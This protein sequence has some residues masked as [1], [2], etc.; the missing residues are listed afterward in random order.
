[1]AI[2][3]EL[4]QTL[5]E[6]ATTGH[7]PLR[8]IAHIIELVQAICAVQSLLGHT[9]VVS[10][11]AGRACIPPQASTSSDL[12]RLSLPP[13]RPF[14]HRTFSVTHDSTVEQQQRPPDRPQSRC[15]ARTTRHTTSKR[16][17]ITTTAATSDHNDENEN[18]FVTRRQHDDRCNGEHEIAVPVDVTEDVPVKRSRRSTRG[19]PAKPVAAARKISSVFKSA[20]SVIDVYQDEKDKVQE[21]PVPATPRHRDAASKKVPI[22]PRHRVLLAGSPFTPRTPRTPSTPTAA[23]TSVYHHARRLFSRCSDPGRLVGRDAERGDITGFLQTCL[24]ST[25]G[26]CLYV[27]GP[28]GTGKSALIGEASEQLARK[29]N[30]RMTTVNCMSVRNTKDLSGKLAEDLGLTDGSG[31]DHLRARFVRGEANEA[32]KYVVI[33]DEVDRLVDLDLELLYSLFEWSLHSASR[34][35]LIGIANALDLTD[36]FLPRLKSRGL[37]PQLLPFMPYTA[38]QV[39]QILH[40]KLRTLCS[41]D[42]QA[43]PFLHPAAIQFCAKKVAG[44]TGDLRKA[45]D[46]CR[47]AIE[48]VEQETRRHDAQ[49]ALPHSP[50][51][52]PLMDN[53]NLSSPPTPRSPDKKPQPPAAYTLATAPKATIAHMAMVTAQVFS[54]GAAQRL[55]LLNLQQKAVLCALAALEKRRRTAAT[56]AAAAS[57]FLPSTPSK[58]ATAPSLRQLFEVYGALCTRENLLHPLTSG[59]FRDVVAGLEAAS[60]V[61]PAAAEGARRGSLALP[62]TP[63][64]TPGRRARM[65]GAV[66]LG[67]ERRIA[68]AIGFDELAAALQGAGAELLRAILLSDGTA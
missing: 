33:L 8:T 46:I 59:E 68:S 41:S 57:P 19:A 27:S 29:E 67:D 62:V 23:A 11:V 21:I 10:R 45:F 14:S 35:I 6:V 17:I 26:G 39:A 48:L 4:Y 58:P 20:K 9:R 28:P 61:A 44:Q 24:D 13:H 64:R 53:I 49:L 63:S 12:T 51:K 65:G 50:S 1:M 34:L 5:G 22:T 66:A 60:L 18:P 31:F 40:A 37:A 36:R 32:C 42:D 7:L 3:H 54:H 15:H 30:V 47:R 43:T 16:R 25:A 2:P 55:A 38:A 56:P 52:T